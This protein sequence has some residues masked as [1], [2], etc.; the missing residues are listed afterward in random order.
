MEIR[1]RRGSFLGGS[2]NEWLSNL[3][4]RIEE[5]G[6]NLA[7]VV[8]ICDNAPIHFHSRFEQVAQTKGFTLLRLGPYSPMLNPIPNVWSIVKAAVE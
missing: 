4:D 1:R 7:I 3:A 8:I 5:R 2:A 6:I